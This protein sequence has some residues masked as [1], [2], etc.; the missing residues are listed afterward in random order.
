MSDRIYQAGTI[1]VGDHLGTFTLFGLTFNGDTIWETAAAAIVLIGLGLFVRAKVTSGVPGGVQLFFE[2]IFSWAREQVE[3]NI[4]L[5]VA[6][7]VVPIATTL[8]IFILIANWFSA[9]PFQFP[10]SSGGLNDGFAPPASDVNFVFAL[11]WVVLLWAQFAG[12]RRRGVGKHFIQLAKGHF[13]PA[14]VINI[15]EEF[16]KFL[17]LPLRLFGNMFGGTIMV[18]III[19]LFPSY[20]LWAPNAIW[21]LFDLFIGAVQAFV[22]ALLTIIYFGQAMEIPEEGH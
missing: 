5:K 17:S 8:F 19:S 2:T 12:A 21:K 1:S 14:A 10:T 13:A 18:T 20:L 16:A 22:F 15:I 3:T 7:F 9:L 11:A 6:P 4:G